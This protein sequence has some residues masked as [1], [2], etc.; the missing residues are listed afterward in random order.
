[1]NIM[2]TINNTPNIVL[3]F[4]FIFIVITLSIIG[5]FLIELLLIYFCTYNLKYTKTYILIVSSLISIVLAFII[6]NEWQS[7]YRAEIN[8]EE[9]ATAL[10]N[11]YKMVSTLPNAHKIQKQIKKYLQSIIYI[12]FPALKQNKVPNNN[13]IL[14]KLQM[15]IYDYHPHNVREA[16]LYQEM[17]TST[18]RAINLR[19]ARIDSAI[20]GLAPELWWVVLLGTTINIVLTWFTPGTIYFKMWMTSLVATVFASLLFL[21]VVLDYP[22]SGDYAI[23]PISFKQVLDNILSK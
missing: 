6:Y 15:M 14:N 1:M 8:T 7:F 19:T 2:N 17:I 21:L 23:A 4:L 5:L 9:E 16:Q 20:N 10:S 22:F 13:V 12:E 11:L 18:N 3:F